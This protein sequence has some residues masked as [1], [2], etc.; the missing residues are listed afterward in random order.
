MFYAKELSFSTA[1]DKDH[2][3]V[4]ETATY[5][6]T[7]SDGS[8]DK[9]SPAV[10]VDSSGVAIGQSGTLLLRG[11]VDRSESVSLDISSAT[12]V[13]TVPFL[14]KASVEKLGNKR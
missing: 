2:K 6:C 4:R 12:T 9:D 3:V 7:T 10:M 14:I 5:I 11:T 8:F 13:K 1:R